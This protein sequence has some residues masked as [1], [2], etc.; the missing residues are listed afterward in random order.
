[1]TRGPTTPEPSMPEPPTPEPMTP[2]PAAPGPRTLEVDDLRVELGGRAVLRGVSLALRAG[3]VAALTGESGSG[4]STT[5]L[6]VMR[7]LPPGA[8]VAGRVALDGRDLLALPEAEMRRV[9]GAAVGLVAQDP[10]AALDPLQRIGAQVAEAVRAHARV[11]RAEATARARAA[12]VR[13]GLPPE[14]AGPRRYPHEISG[15]QRQRATIAMAIAARPGFLVADEPTAA[16][17]VLARARALALLR[18]LVDEEGLGLLLITHDLAAAAQIADTVTVL[19]DGRVVEQ[20]PAARVLAAPRHPH[21]RALVAAARAPGHAPELN[22]GLAPALAPGPPLLELRGVVRDH[23]LPRGLGGL[24]GR[25]PRRRVVR[26]AS[27]TIAR[28]ESVGLVG[29]SGSGKTTLARAVLGLEPVQAGEIR[30]AGEPVGPAM[31]RALRRRVQ[32]VFQDPYGSFDPRWRVERLVAEPL[33]LLDAPPRGAA[34]REAVARALRAVGLAPEDAGRFIHAFS[35]GQRQRVAIARA[36]VIEPE[37]IV[38]D[39]A[40]SALDARVR[41]RVLGLLADLRA[42]RGLAYLFISHDLAVVRRVAQ[43]VLVMR[44]GAIVEQGPTEAV[45]TAPRHP[46]TRALVAAAPQ[47]PGSQ[48]PGSQPPWSQPFG[49][50]PIDAPAPP[51]EP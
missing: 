20:G 25:A 49:P 10:M 15:G 1:M 28:G 33:H 45:L 19:R 7:L 41:A 30:L 4:K 40:V 29:E 8:R 51:R 48:P 35:G 5:A 39:E 46:Y 14:A 32:A 17:D 18:R 26:D 50:A 37:L 24:L 23:A 31:G 16:L 9:R 44:E 38:L 27:F 22:P 47:L 2:E 11:P 21:A 3:R 42:R 6:A 34:R 12:L 36:L 43:R 13:A